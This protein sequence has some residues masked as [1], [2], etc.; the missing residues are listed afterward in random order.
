[1]DQPIVLYIIYSM[2]S[3][4]TYLC[5]ECKGDL[6]PTNSLKYKFHDLIISFINHWVV[7]KKAVH[8][9][10]WLGEICLNLSAVANQGSIPSD[11]AGRG[12]LTKGEEEKFLQ[13]QRP[14][15]NL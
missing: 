1:M 13:L 8:A 5:K 7:N 2:T 15:F 14:R 12:G 6:Q 3:F 11:G 10:S 4:I 9:C